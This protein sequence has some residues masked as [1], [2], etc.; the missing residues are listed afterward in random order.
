[1]LAYLSDKR[2]QRETTIAIWV[3]RLNKRGLVDFGL[4]FAEDKRDR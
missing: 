2:L 3:A 4:L 1:M